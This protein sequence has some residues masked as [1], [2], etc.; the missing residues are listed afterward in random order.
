MR[1]FIKI[2]EDAWH[3]SRHDFDRFSIDHIGTGEGNQ[4]YGWGLY[5]ASVKEVADL[6]RRRGSGSIGQV[7]TLDGKSYDYNSG[8]NIIEHR[9]TEAIEAVAKRTHFE[10]QR[11]TFVYYRNL[12]AWKL[13][14]AIFEKNLNLKEWGEK[15]LTNEQPYDD[16]RTSVEIMVE[17][18]LNSLKGVIYQQPTGKIYKVKLP[19]EDTYILWDQIIQ[20]HFV[21]DA[22][23]KFIS[24]LSKKFFAGELVGHPPEDLSNYDP[25]IAKYLN[26]TIFNKNI[27]TGEVH[28]KNIAMLLRSEKT[29]SL[30]LA[31]YG[32]TGIKYLDG[33]SRGNHGGT[34]NYV[35]FDDK[36]VELDSTER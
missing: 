13:T 19:D 4:A 12:I 25:V 10:S 8:F 27:Y 2:V 30:T 7:I 33:F 22:L 21:Q 26:G 20:S 9:L 16:E 6:Y 24:D 17:A 5:F 31:K 14:G 28:Y 18:A 11:E 23:D 15:F 1:N 36:H 3:G 34:Y 32:I 35:I 29:A